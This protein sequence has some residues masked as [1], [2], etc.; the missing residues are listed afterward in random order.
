MR[1]KRRGRQLPGSNRRINRRLCAVL[2]SVQRCLRHRGHHRC[3]SSRP[4]GAVI[5]FPETSAQTRRRRR[6]RKRASDSSR[7]A[8]TPHRSAPSVRDVRSISPSPPCLVR[9]A[10]LGRDRGI[11]IMLEMKSISILTGDPMAHGEDRAGRD[12]PSP[13]NTSCGL[14][15]DRHSSQMRAGKAATSIQCD[16][17]NMTFERGY[18]SAVSGQIYNLI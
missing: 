16:E 5:G 14:I 3:A 10:F 8:P 4:S 2:I 6:R 17:R 12:S 11:S 9:S 13:H 7:V 15:A 18:L 1:D